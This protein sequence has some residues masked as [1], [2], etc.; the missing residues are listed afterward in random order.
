MQRRGYRK[1]VKT[2]KPGIADAIKPGSI[3]DIMR[4]FDATIRTAKKET[5][6]KTM[7]FEAT[8]QIMDDS[9]AV[10]FYDL[11]EKIKNYRSDPLNAPI[12]PHKI[13]AAFQAM[14][15]ARAK[16]KFDE[17]VPAD[18]PPEA[19]AGPT[20]APHKMEAGEVRLVTESIVFP[21]D[22]LGP[23][24]DATVAAFMATHASRTPAANIKLISDHGGVRVKDTP[25]DRRAAFI[26]EC[27]RA[28]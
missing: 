11:V 23:T 12:Y 2:G 6:T 14:K 17:L 3:D 19:T 27:H 1:P 13:E 18:D 16:L 5:E 26:A 22:V 20:W 7:L 10:L 24:E 4:K 25:A 8:V 21:S 28:P 15:I 9:E